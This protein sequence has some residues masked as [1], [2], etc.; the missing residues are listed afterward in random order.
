MKKGTKDT[1]RLLAVA[2][3]MGLSMV[4][5][6]FIGLAAGY[7]MDQYFGTSPYLTIIFLILGIVAGFRNIVVLLRRLRKMADE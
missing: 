3:T 7:Y 2:S 4:L 6:T 5:A 1:I